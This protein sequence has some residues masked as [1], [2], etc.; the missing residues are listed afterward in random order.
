M[1]VYMCAMCERCGYV[2]VVCM[3]CIHGVCLGV[4]GVYVHMLHVCV[5]MHM[6]VVW[7]VHMCIVCTVDMCALCVLYV[8]CM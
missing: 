3:W 1:C 5:C 4:C 8:V 7:I 6:C 2:C